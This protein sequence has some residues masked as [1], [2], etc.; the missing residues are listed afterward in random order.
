MPPNTGVRGKFIFKITGLH[1]MFPK[2]TETKNGVWGD[3]YG[4]HTIALVVIKPRMYKGTE[5]PH[6]ESR[7]IIHNTARKCDTLY[8]NVM[9]L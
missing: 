7:E 5:K 2:C 6:R 3:F 9:F 1:K 8:Y 4:C